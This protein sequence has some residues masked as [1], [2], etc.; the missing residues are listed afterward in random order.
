MRH[1]D[2]SFLG[3]SKITKENVRMS[4]Y[5]LFPVPSLPQSYSKLHSNA[6]TGYIDVCYVKNEFEC[7]F[8]DTIKLLS[9]PHFSER[10]PP[11]KYT[12]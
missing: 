6:P 10:L 4:P 7:R 11:N 12:I 8:L 2:V 5:R 9:E 1:S 3:C